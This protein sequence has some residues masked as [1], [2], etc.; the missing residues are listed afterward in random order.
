MTQ[1]TELLTA[2]VEILY[3]DKLGY[4]P[5][6]SMTRKDWRAACLKNLLAGR[7]EFEVWQLKM[8]T[9]NMAIAQFSLGLRIDG[10]AS[11]EYS[12]DTR[13]LDFAGHLFD[14][15]LHADNFRFLLPC[16]FNRATFSGEA[17]FESA[18]F[19]EKAVFKDATFNRDAGF[20]S[21]TF[22]G[23]AVF[24]E[25]YSTEMQSFKAPYSTEMQ[26]FKAPYSTEMQSLI[27][28]PPSA[29]MH[30]LAKQSLR[31]VASFKV[32][33]LKNQVTSK[34]QFSKK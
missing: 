30:G 7:N 28:A 22:S 34:T 19:S 15:Y 11:K 26:S 23:K 14:E 5:N 21:A 31:E 33:A 8:L 3:L 1:T 20:E 25:A 29:G 13:T 12:R 4:G 9:A 27:K 24:K 17:R 10:V 16:S 18:T 2:G 32:P 6:G